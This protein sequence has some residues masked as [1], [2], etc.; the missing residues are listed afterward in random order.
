VW[1]LAGGNHNSVLVEL[2]DYVAVVE[3]RLD[4]ERLLAVIAEAKKL[5]PNKPIRYLINT[6]TIL[7]TRA[8]SEPTWRRVRP[9]SRTS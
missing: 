8:L 7:T 6:H 2:K 9:S 3:G 1:F 5:V 4:E